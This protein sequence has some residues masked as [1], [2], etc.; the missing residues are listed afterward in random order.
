[1]KKNKKEPSREMVDAVIEGG[2]YIAE[3]CGFCGVTSFISRDNSVHFCFEDEEEKKEIY[4]NLEKQAKENPEKF[5]EIFDDDYISYG[6]IDN[7]MFVERCPCNVLRN[8]EDFI[9]ENIGIIKKYVINKEAK[10]KKEYEEKI[11]ELHSLMDS[12]ENSYEEKVEK[13]TNAIEKLNNTTT[14]L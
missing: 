9:L 6:Y 2:G 1:M 10:L 11:S 3:E 14:V 4:D 13:A 5:H 12:F 7:R 8:Y